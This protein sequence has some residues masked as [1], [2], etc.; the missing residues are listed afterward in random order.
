MLNG[1]LLAD[2]KVERE[3]LN[4]V[5]SEKGL[6]DAVR[7]KTTRCAACGLNALKDVE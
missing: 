2:H 5:R 6:A 1:N 7:T 3:T 4:V